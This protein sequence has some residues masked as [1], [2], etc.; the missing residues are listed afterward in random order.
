MRG[1]AVRG[2]P[3]VVEVGKDKSEGNASGEKDP[4]DDGALEHGKVRED[5]CVDIDDYREVYEKCTS[6][7]VSEKYG[8]LIREQLRNDPGFLEEKLHP[9]DGHKRTYG[10]VGQVHDHVLPAPDKDKQSRNDQSSKF[11]DG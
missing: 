2:G 11:Y 7:A 5:E 9:Y 1:G 10:C 4:V 3:L 6:A 8:D